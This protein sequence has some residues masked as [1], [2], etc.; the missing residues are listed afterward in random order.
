MRDIKRIYM[1]V[2]RLTEAWRVV[3]IGGLGDF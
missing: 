2:I 1:I 3:P